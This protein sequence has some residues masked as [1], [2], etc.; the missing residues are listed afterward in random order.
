MARPGAQQ[1]AHGGRTVSQSCGDGFEANLG[2]LV[3]LHRQNI[4][5]QAIAVAGERVDQLAAVIGVMKQQHR[6]LAAGVAIDTEQRAQLPQQRVGRRQ[7]VSGGAGRAGGGA[8]AAAGADLRIDA[9]MIASRRDRAGRAQ[10]ETAAA[11]DD[12]RARMRAQIGVEIDVARLV[13]RAA[14][15][16]RLEDSAQ[17]RRRIGRVGAQITVAQVG[18]REQRRVTRQID[19]D[20]AARHRAVARRSEDKFTA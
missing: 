10:V 1:K 3:D 20:I 9:D 14:Q 17:H 13:E 4:R 8:L 7:R 12:L 6:A 5:R 15:I 11:A 18:G 19:Q 2:D 16:A